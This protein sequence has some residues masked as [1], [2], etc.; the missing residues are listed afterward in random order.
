MTGPLGGVILLLLGLFW[1][2]LVVSPDARTAIITFLGNMGGLGVTPIP[3]ATAGAAAG[4][5]AA[6][7]SPF[8]SKYLQTL[9]PF[10]ASAPNVQGP[11]DP[12]TPGALQPFLGST[13]A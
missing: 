5:P 3:S 7:G 6:G 8:N 10:D 9:A 13:H 1:G 11:A 2:V 12:T 4:A